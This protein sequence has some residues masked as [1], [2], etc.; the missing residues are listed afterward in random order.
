MAIKTVLKLL[1]AKFA[2]LSVDMQRA[3]ITDQA[4]INNAETQDVTY[5]DNDETAID[6]ESERVRLMIEQATTD[7][8]LKEIEPHLKAEHLDLFTLKKDELKS[9]K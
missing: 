8:D 7:N 3:V 1:L 2:P 5:V 9:K 4:V 6:K